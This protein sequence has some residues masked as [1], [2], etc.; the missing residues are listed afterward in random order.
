MPMNGGFATDGPG[1]TPQQS[2]VRQVQRVQQRIIA[3]NTQFSHVLAGF[4]L[5]L[6]RLNTHLLTP[7]PPEAAARPWDTKQVQLASQVDR[8]GRELEELTGK[9]DELV[10]QLADSREELG[11][12]L[13][14]RTAVASVATPAPTATTPAVPPPA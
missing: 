10:R 13:G 2:A 3:L 5:A 1:P 7:R 6:E 9:I 11:L 14:M 8:L 12:L 4:N